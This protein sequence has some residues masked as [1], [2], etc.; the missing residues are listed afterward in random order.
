MT[1]RELIDE[2]EGMDEDATVL[3]AHQPSWPL[4]ETLSHVTQTDNR[5]MCPNC[6]RHL[7]AN[8]SGPGYTCP[9]C[10][11]LSEDEVEDVDPTSADA[12]YLVAGG[13]PREG[14]PYAPK[15]VFNR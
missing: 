3:I 14:S 10:G 2:L 11:P 8:H 5:P 9:T 15:E 7:F 6:E 12:V 4:Q 13:H 1:V